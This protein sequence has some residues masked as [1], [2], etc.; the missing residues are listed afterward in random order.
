[1]KMNRLSGYIESLRIAEAHAAAAEYE[2]E[3]QKEFKD[4]KEDLM[5]SKWLKVSRRSYLRASELAAMWRQRA[6]IEWLEAVKCCRSR[7]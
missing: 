7:S 1:M 6:E 2:I 5:Y 3:M 4:L